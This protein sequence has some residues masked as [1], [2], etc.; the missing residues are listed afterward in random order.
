MATEDAQAAEAFG[1][2]IDVLWKVLKKTVFTIGS[3][4]EPVLSAMIDSTVRIVVATSDWIKNN[5]GLIVTVFKVGMAIAAGGA[6]I[7]ALGAAAVGLSTVFGAA[8]SVLV[9][10]GQG[11]AILGTAIAALL[12]PI[13]LTISGLAALVGYFV[14]TSGAGSQAMQWLSLRFS[15]SRR[16]T[17]SIQPSRGSSSQWPPEIRSKSCFGIPAH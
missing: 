12:S 1:D 15:G 16:S 13:G 4:L 11:I 2:R 17:R 7:V 14:Y 9:G 5:K 6:A 3:A 10:I 8:A